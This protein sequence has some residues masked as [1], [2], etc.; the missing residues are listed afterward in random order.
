MTT[1]VEFTEEGLSRLIE[2]QR[3]S[4]QNWRYRSCEVKAFFEIQSLS[5]LK[6]FSFRFKEFSFRA[7]S[8]LTNQYL[9]EAGFKIVKICNLDS[10]EDTSP[11]YLRIETGPDKFEFIYKEA[12]IFVNHPISLEKYIIR[13]SKIFEEEPYQ[14]S[15][16]GLNQE[17][18]NFLNNL[19]KYSE[20]YNF[21][22]NK[23]IKSK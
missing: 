13:F 6:E 2:V 23:K 5:E 20:Q 18:Q 16:Y 11:E 10:E 22:R 9:N 17:G 12:D 19:L 1:K 3:K 21:Y 8:Y 15:V 7:T 4:R 14:I